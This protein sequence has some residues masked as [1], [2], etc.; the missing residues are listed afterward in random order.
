MS[1]EC[2]EGV[3][4]KSSLLYHSCFLRVKPDL[5]SSKKEVRYGKIW[6]DKKNITLKTLKEDL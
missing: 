5:L 1:F 2:P 4:I 6:A 3:P